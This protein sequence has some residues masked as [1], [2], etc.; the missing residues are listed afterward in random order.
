MVTTPLGKPKLVAVHTLVLLAH[1]PARPAGAV[2]NHRD[3]NRSNNHISNLEWCTP[4]ENER[5]AWANG[6]GTK[7]HR[8]NDGRFCN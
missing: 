5:H 8:G 7:I 3:G 2:V 1:G 4:A 6:K